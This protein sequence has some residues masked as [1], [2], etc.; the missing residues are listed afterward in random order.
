MSLRLFLRPSSSHCEEERRASSIESIMRLWHAATWLSTHPQ[1][2]GVGCVLIEY[3]TKIA[4]MK[5]PKEQ[6]AQCLR[7][8]NQ[9]G[10][11]V[12][13]VDLTAIVNAALVPRPQRSIV[14]FQTAIQEIHALAEAA[15]ELYGAASHMLRQLGA[16]ALETYLKAVE[17]SK[18][19][20]GTV[21]PTASVPS[22]VVAGG[23][24]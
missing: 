18:T 16:P 1:F 15:P 5:L 23:V 12:S 6:Q 21:A 19:N 24:R 17:P 14:S 2:C 9:V 22:L 7:L 20:A 11:H 4:V 10:V 13:D 3:A 8:L